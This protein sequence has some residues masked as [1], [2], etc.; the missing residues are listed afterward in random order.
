MSD[1]S[2][3]LARVIRRSLCEQVFVVRDAHIQRETDVVASSKARFLQIDDSPALRRFVSPHK[4]VQARFSKSV[5]LQHRSDVLAHETVKR[6]LCPC[7][8]LRHGNRITTRNLGTAV[9]AASS[10]VAAAVSGESLNGSLCR[11]FRGECAGRTSFVSLTRQGW[12]K[13]K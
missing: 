12:R 11:R 7:P 2:P 9:H 13:R 10:I 8:L 3:L 6:E 5:A 4:P 1:A